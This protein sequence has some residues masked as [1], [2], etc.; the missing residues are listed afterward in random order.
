M[1]ITLQF[2]EKDIVILDAAL[3]QMPYIQVVGLIEKINKQI[4]LQQTPSKDQ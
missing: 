3:K 1:T 4:Q 2:D